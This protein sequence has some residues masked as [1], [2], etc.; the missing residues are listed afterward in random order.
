M[1]AAPSDSPLLRRK[2][3]RPRPPP[4]EVQSS[5]LARALPRAVLRALSAGVGLTGET[6]ALREAQ[7]A[8][9]ELVERV[10]DDGFVALLSGGA[11]RIGE[12]GVIGLDPGLF[13]G[14]IE[15]ATLGRLSAHPPP[16]RRPTP[17]DA[18]LVGEVVDRL[19]EGIGEA[20]GACWRLGR[21]VA[22]LR[23]LGALLEAPQYRVL[24]LD[25]VL[26]DGAVRR[27]GGLM[28]ALPEAAPAPR[29]PSG[30]A[31]AD[32]PG[33]A[34]DGLAAV[35]LGLPVVLEAVLGRV[36]L[37]LDA[38]L[39]LRVGQRF[40]FPISRLEEVVLAGL[41]GRPQARARL[42]QSRG[43]RAVRIVSLADGEG[44]AGAEPEVWPAPDPA[45]DARPLPKSDGAIGLPRAG[46]S[47]RTAP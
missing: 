4:A 20:A 39:A 9:A 31:A 16:P 18:A 29:P 40:E 26:A 36:H 2:V 34:G 38:A 37:P 41:D 42:G 32:P 27:P 22:D 28:L 6:G 44:P 7:L 8:L 19:L 33:P 30:A 45:T 46:P 15:A 11:H 3:L 14:L 25:L 12:A 43:L 13:T 35:A 1:S 21:Q 23:L 10:E 17:T 47:D 5:P 24:R